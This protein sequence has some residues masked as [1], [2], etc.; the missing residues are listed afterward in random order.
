MKTLIVSISAKNVHKQLAPWCLKAY[1]ESKGLDGVEILEVN[2]NYNINEIICKIC[3]REFQILAFSCYIWNIDY[4]NKIGV[5]IKKLFPNVV[6]ILGGPEVSFE[7]DLSNYPF[8]SHIIKGEGEKLFHDLIRNGGKDLTTDKLQDNTAANHQKA[9]F[10]SFPSPYTPDFFASFKNEQIPN[11]E[12]RLVYYESSRGCPFAC[13]YC[14]SSA[15]KG[16]SYLPV[17]RVKSDLLLLLQNGAKTVKFVDRTFNAELKRAKEILLFIKSLQTDC[18]FHFEIAPDIFDDELFEIIKTMPFCRVQFE[19][20]VQTVNEKTLTAINRKMNAELALKNIEKLSSFKNCNIHVGLI[21]GLPHETVETFKTAVD[22]CV[23]ANPH[24]L[25]LGFLKRLKGTKIC[26]YNFGAVFAPFAPYQIFATNTLSYVDI[27]RL[28][29]IESV[30]DKFFNSGAFSQTVAFAVK[31]FKS[32]YAFFEALADFCELNNCNFKTSMKQA[33]SVLLNFLL[34]HGNAAEVE[35]FIKLDCLGFDA[36]RGL[37]PS[38]IKQ[39]RDKRAELA[40]LQQLKVANVRVEFFEFDNTFK[41][42]VYDNK[43]LLTNKFEVKE[44]DPNMHQ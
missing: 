11:I 16:V 22:K 5:L 2:S 25:Q 23:L 17:E 29:K 26:S 7:N 4:V 39:M 40:Y 31:I 38:G 24:T 37:L 18:T 19:V 20:G 6:I 41:L 33:Y 12:N 15:T 43:N 10:A 32:P 30:I 28:K 1:C 13:S 9:C 3:E 14:L 35:Y 8:A 36:C 34:P 27:M 42:F 44:I 21:A